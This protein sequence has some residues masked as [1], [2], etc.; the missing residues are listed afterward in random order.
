MVQKQ[1]LT[2]SMLTMREKRQRYS[3]NI[4]DRDD[5]FHTGSCFACCFSQTCGTLPH[6][7]AGYRDSVN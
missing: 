3:N 1:V 2:A 7:R 6:D 5:D 4:F